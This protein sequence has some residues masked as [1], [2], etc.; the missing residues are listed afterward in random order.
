MMTEVQTKAMD[1]SNETVYF[2][3]ELVAE[4][5]FDED[6]YEFLTKYGQDNLVK[7]YVSYVDLGETHSYDAVDAFIENFSIDDLDKFEDAYYGTYDSPEYF[8]ENLVT[9]VDGATIPEGLIV[10]W[11]ATWKCNYQYDFIFANNCVFLRNI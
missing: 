3:N 1:L 4:N 10:D 5:Y 7:W 2:I 6:I 9:K 8:V 11:T